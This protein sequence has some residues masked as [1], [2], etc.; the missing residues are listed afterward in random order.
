MN[1]WGKRKKD[2]KTRFQWHVICTLIRRDVICYK[3]Q[4]IMRDFWAEMAKVIPSRWGGREG[5]AICHNWQLSRKISWNYWSN[6]C[7][8]N[9]IMFCFDR[10]LLILICK[11]DLSD[12]PI[13]RTLT[14]FKKSLNRTLKIHW[15][16]WLLLV[17]IALV[18]S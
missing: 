18:A 12:F 2:F 1:L 10:I 11:W 15:F 9:Y 3:G 17:K 13:I 8:R 4:K 16:L 7:M 5:V 6:H 14:M